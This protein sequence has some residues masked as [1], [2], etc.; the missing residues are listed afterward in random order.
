MLVDSQEAV[1]KLPGQPYANPLKYLSSIL[2]KAVS[3]G[4][5]KGTSELSSTCP[6]TTKRW[7]PV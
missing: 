4:T 6:T 2:Y 5:S 3:M 7:E 1:I